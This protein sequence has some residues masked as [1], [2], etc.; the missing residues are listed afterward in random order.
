MGFLPEQIVD[1]AL[2]AVLDRFLVR[3]DFSN[4]IKFFFWHTLQIDWS[5]SAGL[6]APEARPLRRP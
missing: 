4:I 2:L 6:A 5:A 1:A 3:K